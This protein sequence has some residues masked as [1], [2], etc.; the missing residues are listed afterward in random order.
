[1]REYIE[2]MMRCGITAEEATRICS[3]MVR[4]Y[5]YQELEELTADIERDNYVG[6]V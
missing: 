4:D 5:G 2:R 3:A 1:M 6:R